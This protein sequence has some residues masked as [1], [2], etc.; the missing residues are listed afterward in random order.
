MKKHRLEINVFESNGQ[1]DINIIHNK[2]FEGLLLSE[3]IAVL[4]NITGQLENQNQTSD[5]LDKYLIEM[6]DPYK[7][8]ELGKYKCWLNEKEIGIFRLVD[9]I[10]IGRS[11]Q[12]KQ[13]IGKE[14]RINVATP[15]KWEK[16]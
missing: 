12:Q 13:K 8:L 3:V 2:S 4:R 10:N 9:D 5:S 16:L 15:D 14:F 1:F 7:N 6:N 11:F